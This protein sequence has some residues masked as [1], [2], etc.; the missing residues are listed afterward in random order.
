MNK[1]PSWTRRASAGFAASV[2][3]VGA[4]ALTAGS[5][6]ASAAPQ[7]GASTPKGHGS[8]KLGSHDHELLAQARAKGD[9]TV[10]L[11]VA[12]DKGR[13]GSVAA[14]LRKLGATVARQVDGVGYVRAS[15]PTDAVLR[16]AK[17]PGVA[18]IDLNESVPLPKP[19]PFTTKAD[20][21]TQGAAVAAPGPD[22][23]AANPYMPTNETGAVAFKQAHPEWDGRGVTIGIMDSGVDLDN[24]ALQTTSTGERKIVD[25]FTA[26]DPIFD[27]DGTWRAMLTSVAGPTF[28]YAGAT[29][30]APEG[31]WRINRFSESITSGDEPGGDLNKDGDKTDTFGILYDPE[32]HDIRV[33]SN[34]NRDFTDDAVMRPYKE[35]YDVGHFGTDDPATAI[36]ERTPFVVEYREDVD[37]SPYGG[38]YVGQKSDFVNIG[39]VEAQH[40]SH[41]AGITAANDMFGDA[42]F[43]GAAPGAKLVSARACSWGGGCTYAALTDGMVDLVVNRHVDVVNMSIGGLPA[44]N[45]ANNA[46]AQLYDRLINDYGVQLFISAGN[47]GPGINT[48]GDPS[49]ASSVVSVAAGVSKE[50]WLANYGSVT[51]TPYQLFNF[52]SRGPREDGGFKPTIT[53]PGSAIST[54]PLWQPGGPVPEAGYQLPP[55][56]SMLN[57]TSMASP[58]ATGAAALLLSAAKANGFAVAPAELRR[59]IYSSAKWID[60]VPAHGQGNGLFNTVGAWDL[61]AGHGVETRGYSASAPVCTPLSGFLSTANTGT[62]VYNRCAV[63]QGGQRANED[64]TYTVTIT[65]T[66]GPNKLIRHD[67]TLLGNDGTFRDYP[68]SVVLPL[69][70]PVTLRLET[71]GGYGVHSAVM[72]VDDPATAGV[73]FELLNT[74]VIGANPAAPGYGFT[75]SGSVDRNLFTSYFVNVPAGASALQVNLSGLADGSQTRFIAFNPYGVPVESTS[76]LGC[77]SNF[78]DAAAC[79]PS[80]RDYANPMPG[81]W[82][83]EVESR[84]TSPTLE[85]PFQ[86]TARVQGVKVE[87]AV[88]DLPSVTAG[89][90]TPVT[91]TLTNQFGPVNVSGKGGALGSAAIKRPSI[92]NGETLTYEVTVPEGATRLDVAIGKTSDLGADLDLYVFRGTTRVGYSA[93]GDS[94]EAVSLANPAAGVYTVEIDGYSVPAGTTEFDYRDVFYS[95]SLG[96][97]SAPST[98]LPLANGGTGTIT[99]SVTASMAPAAGRQLFG[100]LLVVTDEGATVGRGN[101]SIGAVN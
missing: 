35:R 32:S 100:E 91:W 71:N 19:E 28:S 101:V 47:S 98:T 80:E 29:W 38:P 87:P 90:A 43:D 42:A 96:S 2:V 40:G 11:I 4:I 21:A 61:L 7:T 56:Y 3:A 86:L 75:T 82:E 34:Q 85:N 23:P 50:T 36:A 83:I 18:A 97:V 17:L 99:G 26:T 45:D 95:A 15:V 62:G 70:K 73:D 24:A 66:S 49:V 94:E 31:N 64:K 57:G 51:R 53:A 52:S 58:Q 84:R 76:S 92:A 6:T 93:D 37:L 16:A 78:S 25:W 74:V 22:T 59:S 27:S 60:G 72:R 46:R 12:T 33:D 68:H 89:Q 54:T 48:V 41:V 30:T 14:E 13:A 5:T 55:G 69:N 81:L 44:L 1:P 67:V 10:M 8:D 9:K 39:I 20:G 79:K 65:R 88:V 63:G 77:Y